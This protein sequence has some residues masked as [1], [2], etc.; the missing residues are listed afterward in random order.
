VPPE[1]LK[2]DLES[3]VQ[4][5][6]SGNKDAAFRYWIPES[7]VVPDIDWAMKV[8]NRLVALVESLLPRKA[9]PGRAVKSILTV[10]KPR[11]RAERK[12][13]DG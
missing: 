2:A 3:I 10:G 9:K 4:L 6:D 12:P 1:D 7:T 13:P 5:L 8:V 11:P